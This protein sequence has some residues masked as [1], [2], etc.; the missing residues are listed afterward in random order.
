[1]LGR[2]IG[3][4]FIALG[5]IAAL[6]ALGQARSL[7]ADDA[8][9]TQPAAESAA[10]PA[11]QP[12]IAP[13]QIP[14][15]TF[16][17][18]DYGA[19]GDGTTVNTDAIQKAIDTC[20]QAGGGTVLVPAGKFLTGPLKLASN[21]NFKVDDGATLLLSDDTSL[22]SVKHTP[23]EQTN[24]RYQNCIEARDVHDLE[25]SGSGTIDGQGEKW[26]NAFRPFKNKMSDPAAPPHRP[27]LILI[28]N[29][30]RLLVQ[31]ITLKNSPMLH[32]VPE[33]CQNVLIRNIHINAPQT[34]PN[35]DGID[36]SGQNIFITKCVI[37]NGDDNI[38]MK[39]VDVLLPGH[40]ACENAL[41]ADCTFKH[42][43]GMGI[44]GQT[45][46]GLK[47][48]VVRNCT[49]EN[50]DWG[51]RLKAPRGE[52]GTVE[53]VTYE[54]CTMKHVKIAILIESY[55][56]KIPTDPT[57]DPP[58]PVDAD[59]PIWKNIRF[60]NITAVGGRTAG[61]IAGLPEMPVSDIVFTNVHITATEPFEI[62][63]AQGVKFVNSTVTIPLPPMLKIGN[64]KVD[65]IDPTSGQ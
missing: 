2:S 42:G 59:T 12:D 19:T 38:V 61:Q 48:L 7:R 51:I 15:H 22:Y 17:I 26:W 21:M 43:H 41:I 31:D 30:N 11:T 20:S 60:N 16:N 56:P 5:T 34:A 23:H 1:M 55:Y 58:Q 33:A 40:M 18:T 32:L 10:E 14:D 50:N 64:A 53:D 62:Y 65:G 24:G 29:C 54:D 63:N 47:N 9:T 45:P 4:K 28:H 8:A 57:Q 44:G 36:V 49:F 37:D 39:P 25:L 46:G 6:L 13:P 35:T 27:W 52:G 3:L